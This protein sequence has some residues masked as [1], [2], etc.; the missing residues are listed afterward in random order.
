MTSTLRHTVWFSR[1]VL[2]AATLLFSMIAFRN[3]FDPV[4]AM[5]PH[6]ITL[7]SAAGVTVARVGFGGFPLAFAII[8]LACLAAER[9]LLAGLGFLAVL[10]LVVTA[11]RVIGLV[12]DGPAP[13]TLHVLK[14]EVAL[15]IVSTT[16]F[17]LERRRRRVSMGDDP[18]S[19]HH[20]AL[21]HTSAR[22][23]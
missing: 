18:S 5:A 21:P 20:A 11:A 2:L 23:A 8:L 10:A 1:I 6:E 12:L 19:V 7:G 14:P 17:V 22:R 3:L 9:R 13:F 15:I 16:A 4:G